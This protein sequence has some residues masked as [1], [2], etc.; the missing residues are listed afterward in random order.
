MVHGQGPEWHLMVMV[1]LVLF[2]AVVNALDP[3]YQA[4]YT[5]F[6]TLVILQATSIALIWTWKHHPE[7]AWMETLCRAVS[8]VIFC[9]SLQATVQAG[10]DIGHC[11]ESTEHDRED[12][13]R[14]IDLY[15]SY[16]ALDG[17]HGVKNACATLGK[18]IASLLGG[19]CLNV[20]YKGTTG[21]APLSLQVVWAVLTLMVH[22]HLAFASKRH[23]PDELDS[24]V[25]EAPAYAKKP[26]ANKAF[27][28][29]CAPKSQLRP[30]R[31]IYY[32]SN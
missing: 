28:N 30:F 5:T 1:V 16:A 4:Y 25:E 6:L 14:C 21:E 17:P 15:Y 31:S 18:P 23:S 2:A 20:E 3:S 19:V 27:N 13:H 22:G 10:R 29:T 11:L 7:H 9:F 12:A 24:I 32:K 8:F 26:P